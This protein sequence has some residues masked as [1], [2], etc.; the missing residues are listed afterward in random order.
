MPPFELDLAA[1][2]GSECCF[3][4]GDDVVSM[5]VGKGCGDC[6]PC[7]VKCIDGSWSP[8]VFVGIVGVG[9]Q[10]APDL[11]TQQQ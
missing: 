11:I 2:A 8:D 7:V 3:L 9:K 4:V 5:V 10:N 6:L 1:A